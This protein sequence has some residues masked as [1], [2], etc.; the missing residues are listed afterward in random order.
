L[1]ALMALHALDQ[2][3]DRLGLIA[4]RLEVRLDDE[5]LAA[6]GLLRARRAMRRPGDRTFELGAALAQQVLQRLRR[7]GDAHRLDVAALHRAALALRALELRLRKRHRVAIEPERA[8]EFRRGF[9]QLGVAGVLRLRR[10]AEAA[11]LFLEGGGRR[12]K[13]GG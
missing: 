5:P 8:R 12:A 10:L 3:L 6:F 1:I 4:L 2:L 11:Y 7:R 9:D 13:R